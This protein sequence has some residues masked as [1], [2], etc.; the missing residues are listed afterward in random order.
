M[1]DEAM[2]LTGASYLRSVLRPTLAA[3]LTEKKPCEIDPARVKPSAAIATNLANLK[4][5]V[6]RV[7]SAITQ[8]Y[9]T[10]PAAMCRLFDALRACAARHFPRNGEVRYSVVSGFIFLRF[11]A[12]A[13]LGPR[14][15]DL[16]TE[17]ID[18]QTNRTLTLIS[19]TIQSLGNLVSS[20]SAQ[21]VCKEE[22]M[23]ELYKSF[24]TPRHSLGNLVSSRSAQ[25]VCKEEYMAELYKSFCTPRHVQ[26]IRQFLEI[27]STT[28]DTQNNN[29]QETPVLLKEG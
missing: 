21:Q 20:R 25:Q 13:I 1:M 29:I 12:P 11:F 3:V 10:C 7:F 8:S 15:F 24:C 9:A 5:Y 2:R 19:K 18:P 17:Q 23:A 4:D 27:I 14:L 28:T 16:T 6:E 22:Y 26:A